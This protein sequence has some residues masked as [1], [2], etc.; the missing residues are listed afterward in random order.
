[1]MRAVTVNVDNVR[2]YLR[3][4][5]HN[6]AVTQP[7]SPISLTW[8]QVRLLKPAVIHTHCTVEQVSTESAEQVKMRRRFKV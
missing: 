1:M 6:S 8:E 7:Q 2:L 3:K 5:E 4:W